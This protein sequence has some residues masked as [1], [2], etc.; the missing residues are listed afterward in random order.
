MTC[1]YPEGTDKRSMHYTCRGCKKRVCGSVEGCDDCMLNY[2]DDCWAK[3][4]GHQSV[5]REVQRAS[6]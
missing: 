4:H 2:C 3:A 5:V 6:E 1:G